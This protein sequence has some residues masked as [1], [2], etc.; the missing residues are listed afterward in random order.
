MPAVVFFGTK[1]ALAGDWYGL[2]AGVCAFRV[3]SVVTGII[4]MSEGFRR[5]RGGHAV[6]FKIH[7]YRQA[8]KSAADATSA[9]AVN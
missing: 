7:L 4:R 3:G 5:K 2:A 8:L 6:A 9:E 1:A